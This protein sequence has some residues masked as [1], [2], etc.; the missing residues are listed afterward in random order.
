M[1]DAAVR[2]AVLPVRRGCGVFH[3]RRGGGVIP[4]LTHGG[5]QRQPASNRRLQAC[6]RAFR[7]RGAGRG[8][9]AGPAA[10]QSIPPLNAAR[11]GKCQARGGMRGR[12]GQA[13]QRRSRPFPH[14]N[15]RGRGIG[16][17]H[18]EHL[19]AGLEAPSCVNMNFPP[20]P[21][22][23]PTCMNLHACG[24][25]RS[26]H[27]LQPAPRQPGGVQQHLLHGVAGGGVVGLGVNHELT[28]EG[29]REGGERW[30]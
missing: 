18:I 9:G 16:T 22:L 2:G 19:K 13:R 26:P 24:L 1:A 11:Q 25:Q 15:S 20:S 14:K 10:G 21:P 23:P 6:S 4:S 29:G 17:C 30:H 12:Q 7:T 3:Q 28:G 27:C 8:P 5:G